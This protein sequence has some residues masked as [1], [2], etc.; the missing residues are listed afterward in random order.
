MDPKTEFYRRLA[1]NMSDMVALHSPDG[2]YRWVSPSSKRILGYSPEEMLGTDP[3]LLFHPDDQLT[4]RNDTHVKAMRGDGNIL[5]RY[6]IRHANGNYIWFETLTQPIQDENGVV[7]ELHTT[8]RDV[9]EQ[10]ELEQTLSRNEAVYRTGLKSLEEGVIV[11][12]AAG[13]LITY[14]DQALDIL[15]FLTSNCEG[16]L[17]EKLVENVSYP[18]GEKCEPNNFPSSLT[19]KSGQSHSQVL[20]GIFNVKNGAKRWV[21]F[22]SR[23]V[24]TEAKSTTDAPAVVLSCA[25]VT[26]R[27][28]REQKLQLWST[29]FQFS[30]EA[31]V[32]INESGTITDLN[33]AFE[34]LFKSERTLWIGKTVD[35]ITSNSQSEGVFK[36]DIWP[37]LEK[38]GNWRGELWLRDGDG[39][40]QTTWASITR[41]DQS[42]IT[43]THYT[44]SMSDFNERISKEELLR[45][46]AS[47][48]SLTGLPNRLLLKDRFEVAMSTANRN[49]Q[50][51]GCFYLDLDLFKPVNDKHGHAAGDIV[52]KTIAQRLEKMVRSI[53]TVT[54]IGGD[55]FFVIIFGLETVSEYEAIAKRLANEIMTPIDI[56]GTNIVIGVSIGVAIYPNHGATQ[57]Q[58]MAVSDEAM[59]KAKNGAATVV[60][61]EINE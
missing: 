49:N 21:S 17:F 9:S 19:L 28:E 18:D 51:L 23:P 13:Q 33:K 39:S 41:V 53:D 26:E 56:G 32:I 22:N 38:S 40:I 52:L 34:H 61:A 42:L 3:Y 14:N 46:R 10:Q 12:N 55:E 25:D 48:D 2:R 15:S 60:I 43:N 37:A 24:S 6:R 20:L 7:V 31:I 50:K 35:E 30:S 16:E 59:Y 58:L 1:E 47:H 44:L 27:I 11:L 57:E 54:R 4:I 45:F 36:S 5:I 8:S 29:V